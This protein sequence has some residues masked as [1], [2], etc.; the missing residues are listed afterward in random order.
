MSELEVTP[1]QFDRNEEVLELLNRVFN[2]WVGDERYFTWKYLQLA[3][4][5]CDFPKGWIIEKD[6]KIVAFNGYIPRR[7]WNGQ[8][9][10]WVLQS[11]DTATDP[12][13]RGAGLFGIL[14]NK[15]YEQ[16]RRANIRWV[17][18]WTSQIGFKVFTQKSDWK[19]W[20]EQRYLMK[21][22]NAKPFVESKLGNPL[23]RLA[24]RAGVAAYGHSRKANSIPEISVR[25]EASFS[26]SVG[27]MSEEV[28]RQFGIV[29]SRD[30]KYLQWRY[31]N[32]IEQYQLLCAYSGGYPLGYAVLT[33]RDNCL[34]IDDCV[35]STADALLAL[36]ACI[37]GIARDTP[38]DMIRFRVNVEHQWQ[39]AFKSAG[40]FWSKTSFPM[41]GR[42]IIEDG[43]IPL[44]TN[45]LHWTVFD[46]N[47]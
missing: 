1:Y 2:P 44:G 10:V 9:Y 7:L 14:Q 29:A 27:F 46:R 17:Y 38:M 30:T 16:M 42:F 31:S 25:Q 19:I 3:P 15:V 34:D 33:T 23:A 47:E 35:A 18:G 4:D 13:C 20:G 45:Y 43:A 41:L 8:Q 24:A 28:C 37:E 39:R 6:G 21:V 12:G 32:P 26:D 36:L 11:F 40:Y 22:I 5:G